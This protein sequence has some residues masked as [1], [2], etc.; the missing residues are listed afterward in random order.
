ML[1]IQVIGLLC[2]PKF[3]KMVMEAGE[4]GLEGISHRMFS[5]RPDMLHTV[6]SQTGGGSSLEGK[7]IFRVSR[8]KQLLRFCFC[9]FT[10][11]FHN[12]SL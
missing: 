8:G 2:I 9:Y 11:F 5:G 3:Q 12:S 6:K 7:C 4:G 1:C 10:A